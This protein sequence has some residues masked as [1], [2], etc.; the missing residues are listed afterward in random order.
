MGDNMKRDLKDC[1][2]IIPIRI[3]STDRLRNIITVFC[4]IISNFD[5]N[6]I[7]KEVDT[8]SRFESQALPQIKEF[9]GDVSCIN[10]IFEKSHEPLFLREKILNEM[11][12][13]TKTKVVV[14]YDC[15]VVFPLESYEESYRRIMDNQSDM[16][17]PYGEGPYQYKIF[18]DDQMVTDFLNNDFN[19]D[20]LKKKS[21]N[22]N[23]GEGWVQFLN[24]DV[25]FKGGMENENFMGSAP[26]DFERR[27]RFTTLGY[28]VH[29]VNNYICHLEHSRGMNSYPQSMTQ[30]P[31]WKHN[32]AL[33][34]QLKEY[35][36]EQ[37][38]EYYSKQNYLKKYI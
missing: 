3:E 24:R 31:Y 27:Y 38:I 5:T 22:D 26:D 6:I 17:Y 21:Y 11:L 37:L 15:D 32:W 29:R 23:A 2:F 16:V 8:E 18:C 25:Y 4:Y 36:K 1:T 10:H 34:E 7:V 35:S 28:R 9:C 30:H 13:L 12:V 33:W 20:I 19:F 14:N